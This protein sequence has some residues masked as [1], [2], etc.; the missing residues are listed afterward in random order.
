MSGTQISSA[1]LA[2]RRRRALYQAW[3]RGMREM[4]ILLGKFAD[5]HLAILGESELADFEHLLNAIDRDLLSW[6]TGEAPLPQDYNT[7]VMQ[8]LMAFHTHDGPIQ[9]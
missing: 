2:P 5:A 3:H 1:G 4:D 7:P 8:K 9:F 6:M